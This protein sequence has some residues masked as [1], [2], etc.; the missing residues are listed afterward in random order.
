MNRYLI[1]ILRHVKTTDAVLTDYNPQD[2]WTIHGWLVRKSVSVERV[3][4]TNLCYVL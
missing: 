2:L 3:Q 4:I 1:D